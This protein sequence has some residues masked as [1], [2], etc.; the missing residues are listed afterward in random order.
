MPSRPGATGKN[1]SAQARLQQPWP[2]DP[3]ILSRSFNALS[4]RVAFRNIAQDGGKRFLA[5]YL[6]PGNGRLDGE[7][8]AIGVQ[9]LNSPKFAIFTDCGAGISEN[10]NMPVMG[11]AK[12]FGDK[13]LDRYPDCFIR[14]TTKHFFRCGVE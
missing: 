5:I 8:L 12:P 9:A 14:L 1:K 3:A 4:T 7:L 13:P 10:V 2:V 6:A 11:G